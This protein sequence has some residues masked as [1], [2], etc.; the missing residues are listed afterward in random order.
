MNSGYRFM[1][2]TSFLLPRTRLQRILE[3]EQPQLVE[4][5]DK[6]SLNYLAA[7]LRERLLGRVNFRPAIV[8][9]SCERMDDNVR[10]YITSG[11][12]GEK[13]A[14]FYMRRLYFPFFD[15]HVANSSYTADELRAASVDQLTPRS[16]WIRPM[17]V[18]LERLSPQRRHPAFRERLLGNFGVGPSAKLLL[19]VGR[20]VPEKNLGLLFGTL[21]QLA[22]SGQGGF[23]LLVVGDGIEREPWERQMERVAPGQVLF[24]GHA[25]DRE[26]LADVYA[27]ADVFVHPNPREPFGIA[28]LEAM[29]S[30]VPVVVPNAGGVL[31]YANETNAWTAEP[32]ISAFVAAVQRATACGPDRDARIAR[33]VQTATRYRWESVAAE[34]LDLYAEFVRVWSGEAPAIEPAFGSKSSHGVQKQALCAL[35]HAAKLGYSLSTGGK[36]KGRLERGRNRGC[37][38]IPAEPITSA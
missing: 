26:V 9:L 11:R 3:S 28:P 13:A 27:N 5:C 24:F 4:V 2:P 10:S 30:G 12:L 36:R 17:G 38:N 15:F 29:A 8:G 31:S 6:Y 33:A 18:D 25:Q 14:S 16:V 37:R 32:E 22:H 34:F 21:A 19:Y 1:Y 7:L 35:A 20:L 23:R